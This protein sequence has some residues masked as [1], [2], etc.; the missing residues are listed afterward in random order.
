MLALKQAARKASTA[1]STTNLVIMSS[2]QGN[3]V[4]VWPHARRQKVDI[5]SKESMADLF[6]DDDTNINSVHVDKPVILICAH[7]TRDV[8]CGT[9][10][11]L[12][13]AEFAKVLDKTGVDAHLGTVTHIG[14]HIYAG[15]VIILKPDGNV[16]W[17]GMVRPH[18]VQGIVQLTVLGDTV[19]KE[20]CR[21]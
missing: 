3:D 2:I 10:G 19:I 7:G 20:L 13:H 21:N 8:R 14:G 17:Y 11:A 1:T 18:H 16:V 9:I 5:T 12:V 15:N 4:F 6:N